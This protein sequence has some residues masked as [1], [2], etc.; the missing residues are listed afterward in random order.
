MSDKVYPH[1]LVIIKFTAFPY[2]PQ[3]LVIHMSSNFCLTKVK[4]REMLALKGNI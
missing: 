2:F 3:P 4:K 1:V